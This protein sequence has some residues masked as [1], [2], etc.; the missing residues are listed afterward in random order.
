MPRY[1]P[2]QSV[3]AG[4]RRATK[5]ISTSSLRNTTNTGAKWSTFPTSSTS[6]PIVSAE[7]P[8]KSRFTLSP[9][10]EQYPILSGL[11]KYPVID[12]PI[13][14]AAIPPSKYTKNFPVSALLQTPEDASRGQLVFRKKFVPGYSS[15]YEGIP[16]APGRYHITPESLANSPSAL[17]TLGSDVIRRERDSSYLRDF[18]LDAMHVK[19]LGDDDIA[20]MIYDR[21]KLIAAR[22][23]LE[24]T[25]PIVQN[26]LLNVL[27]FKGANTLHPR[28][29]QMTTN[30]L[31]PATNKRFDPYSYSFS[32]TE[33]SKV[34]L[35]SANSDS[36]GFYP[37]DNLI[38][39]N[40]VA[41][42][43]NPATLKQ[44]ILS[45]FNDYPVIYDKNG[46]KIPSGNFLT[47][48]PENGI[49]N[50]GIFVH[51]GVHADN[52]GGV[53]ITHKGIKA[54][55]EDQARKAVYNDLLGTSDLDPLG[56]KL[57][58]HNLPISG[59]VPSVPAYG[60]V[61][62]WETTRGMGIPKDVV[63][64]SIR[65]RVETMAPK[66]IPGWETMDTPQRNKIIADV[67]TDLSFN[68]NL[69]RGIF[70]QWIAPNGETTV[71]FSNIKLADPTYH[72]ELLRALNTMAINTGKDSRPLLRA[73]GTALQN[74]R[75]KKAL[76]QGRV[77]A[78][79][80]QP[81]TQP[82]SLADKVKETVGLKRS[83]EANDAW[84]AYFEKMW[85]QMVPAVGVT[86]AAPYLYSQMQPQQQTWN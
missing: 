50:S 5:P 67:T 70:D 51:E 25:H 22:N 61:F 15:S 30:T 19:A 81:T 74:R 80:I 52:T 36:I 3:T 33:P 31:G 42:D 59:I 29:I 45:S 27:Q 24:Y 82:A 64:N 39:I 84:N 40:P 18:D 85:R 28:N 12:N 63:T 26:N 49:Y 43:T 44:R 75:I 55:P 48:S 65:Q 56:D 21:G 71:N 78:S 6:D 79:V 23:R 32:E 35:G 17:D 9:E 16:N 60:S 47:K 38:R 66:V 11:D 8:S 62:S 57:S 77:P 20:R 73:I 53:G 37:S 72:L 76:K 68:N 58:N 54:L 34:N 13:F 46:V 10:M 1:N 41:L 7:F 83:K 69:A 86:A 4:V 14:P 2:I